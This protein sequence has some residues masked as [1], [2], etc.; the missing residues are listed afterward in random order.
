MDERFARVRSFK[1]GF[2]GRNP[3]RVSAV[4]F[5]SHPMLVRDEEDVEVTMGR[6]LLPSSPTQWGEGTRRHLSGAGRHCAPIPLA[7]T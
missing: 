7:E 1:V 2:D 6:D 3:I 4:F 5:N